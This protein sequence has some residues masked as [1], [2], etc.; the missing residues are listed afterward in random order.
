VRPDFLLEE[1]IWLGDGMN[2]WVVIVGRRLVREGETSG[3]GHAFEGRGAGD[4][5]D[6]LLIGLDIEDA[7]LVGLIEGGG[8]MVD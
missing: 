7:L 2:K 5:V 8:L 6:G 3:R 4:A 1:T